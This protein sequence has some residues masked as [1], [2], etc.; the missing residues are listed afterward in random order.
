[1]PIFPYLSATAGFSPSR[2]KDQ[3]SNHASLRPLPD[4][5]TRRGMLMEA[6]R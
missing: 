5:A 3:G 4:R 1:M 2:V 6:T